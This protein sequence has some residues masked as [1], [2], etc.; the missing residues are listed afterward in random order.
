[1]TY[2]DRLRIALQVLETREL[3][4]Q[5]PRLTRRTRQIVVD[6]DVV[7]GYA[8]VWIVRRAH[9]NETADET[10]RFE[11]HDGEWRYQGGG[12]GE[13][14]ADLLSRVTAAE[15]AERAAR[16]PSF[17]QTIPFGQL[18]GG[19][20]GQAAGSTQFQVIP[21][22]VEIGTEGRGRRPVA[23]HGYC[24]I[25]FENR[26]APRI[27]GFDASGA[28]LGSFTPEKRPRRP[29]PTL[30]SRRHHGPGPVPLRRLRHG[31]LPWRWPHS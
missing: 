8:S 23:D 22:C 30:F 15:V 6:F 5:P 25:A 31:K 13:P 14:G 9:G 1:M 4:D 16:L 24:L 10:M 20:Y 3:P 7:G 17:V 27:T 29:R 26:R 2:E 12:G 28:S 18:L 11:R 21:E 19:S